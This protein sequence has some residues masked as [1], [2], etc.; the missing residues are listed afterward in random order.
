MSSIISCYIMGGLGNQLF[1]IFTT[2]AYGIE[3]SKKIV[4][5]YTDI[6]PSSVLRYTF[7]DTFLKSLLLFTT[8]K[9]KSIEN[10]YLYNL[11]RIKEKTFSYTKIQNVNQDVMLFGYYQ[12]YK[13]FDRYLHT[14]F[15]ML[16]IKK[17]QEDVY[18]KYSNYFNN[19]I[20]ETCG[21]HFRL[22]DYK[23]IQD[24][25]PIMPYEYYNNSLKYLTSVK[26]ITRVLYFCQ[27]EDNIIVDKNIERLQNINHDIEFVK[28][29]DDIPD[30]CQMLLMSLC[31]N[32]I[33]ANSSFSWWGAYLCNKE[34]NEVYYPSVW[35]GPKN[36]KDTHDLFPNH[37]KKVFV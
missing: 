16:R 19:N 10:N 17:Q 6:S 35:F 33:I 36:Q 8:N 28:V 32:Q 15:N 23:D 22:G 25:H 4:F 24:Y 18:E 26:H 37:W 30:W 1:Q 31:D 3:H 27:K 9:N 20:G 5:P 29:S 11:P 7:W 21:I 13:Y 2:I 14:I 34:R 12:S